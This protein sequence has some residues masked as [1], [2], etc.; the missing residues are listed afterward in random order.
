[1]RE[2]LVPKAPQ[3]MC[4]SRARNRRP[5]GPGASSCTCWTSIRC[6][7]RASVTLGRVRGVLHEEPSAV[8]LHARVREGGGRCGYGDP[9]RARSRKRRIEPR[10]AYGCNRPSPT[11]SAPPSTTPRC[12]PKP[13]M[14]RVHWSITTSTQW[15][16]CSRFAPKQIKTPQTV[17]RVTKHREP[18]RSRRVWCR[19]VPNSKNA[20]HHILV[21]GNTERECDLVRDPGTSPAWVPLLH[22]DDR[23]DDV[24][25]GTLGA[26]PRRPFGREE[27]AIRPLDQRSMKAQHR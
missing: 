1:M 5:C 27:A 19:L 22:V 6:F 21:D 26:R 17:C 16:Q 13:T 18:G 7:A 10:E 12:T 15:V 25:A 4:P 9:T 3:V 8:T 2:W 23:S 20:P 11:R 24:L 14:R